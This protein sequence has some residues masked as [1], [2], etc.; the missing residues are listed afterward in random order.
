M[1]IRAGSL[2]RIDSNPFDEVIERGDRQGANP[3]CGIRGW[4]IEGMNRSAKA[5]ELD[6]SCRRTASSGGTDDY[7]PDARVSAVDLPCYP[8]AVPPCPVPP[9]PPAPPAPL[10]PPLPLGPHPLV[11]KKQLLVGHVHTVTVWLE[12]GEQPQAP[13]K[14][15]FG[16]SPWLLQ[17]CCALTCPP[18]E[19]HSAARS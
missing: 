12:V 6:R 15:E 18:V 16:K 17:H 11:G 10:A 1:V 3:Y 8:P 19:M 4:V 5:F 14:H 9:W 2:T 7:A 13:T